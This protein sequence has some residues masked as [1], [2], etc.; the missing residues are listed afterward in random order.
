VTR[1]TKVSRRHVWSCDYSAKCHLPKKEGAKTLC[2]WLSITRPSL[3]L[4]FELRWEYYSLDNEQ[5]YQNAKTYHLSQLR[6]SRKAKI[7]IYLII[8]YYCTWNFSKSIY[9]A[10]GVERVCAPFHSCAALLTHPLPLHA[11]GGTLSPVA[12][13][14]LHPC[15]GVPTTPLAHPPPCMHMGAHCHP[16]APLLWCAHPSI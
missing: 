16:F 10:W 11:C 3:Q 5:Y 2:F 13:S 15:F 6:I 7:K 4:V 9:W 1:V 8:H 14:F 12:S